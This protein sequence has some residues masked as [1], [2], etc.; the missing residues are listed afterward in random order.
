[1]EE[2]GTGAGA[3]E[4][5]SP[6][7][8]AGEEGVRGAMRTHTEG[9][10]VGCNLYT[11]QADEEG[12][13][14]AK[15]EYTKGEVVRCVLHTPRAG[16]EGVWGDEEGEDTGGRMGRW[17]ERRRRRDVRQGRWWVRNGRC[18]TRVMRCRR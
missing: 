10:G 18:V 4:K 11:P 13:W 6:I 2:E 8:Q 16:E 3:G 7:P 14:G 15:R 17:M 12:A 1:M 9:E 5:T